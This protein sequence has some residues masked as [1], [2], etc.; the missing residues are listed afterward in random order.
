MSGWTDRRWRKRGAG[1]S[2]GSPLLCASGGDAVGGGIGS[3]GSSF[4]QQYASYRN[5]AYRPLF[6]AGGPSAGD[7]VQGAVANCW[8]L[9][10]LASIA[11]ADP[12]EIRQRVMDLGDGTYVVQFKSGST[13][14]HVRVDGDL[15]S[16]SS[17]SLAFAGFGAGGSIWAAIVEKAYAMF[18][19]GEAT[20][21]SLESG[22]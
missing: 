5:F 4:S 2:I 1:R 21:Q 20:Y 8:F 14:V 17:S 3:G 10:S 6:G 22:G 16:Y 12:Q 15:P 13:D 19:K 11:K 18:R 7:V 9:A